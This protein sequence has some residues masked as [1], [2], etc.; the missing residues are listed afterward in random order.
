MSAGLDPGYHP[1][2]RA[3]R[4]G[5][6]SGDQVSRG[7]AERVERS[8]ERWRRP[9]LA[10]GW[11]GRTRRAC[12]VAE[13]MCADVCCCCWCC[14]RSL[15]H[16]NEAAHH[17][18][19]STTSHE[20]APPQ[21]AGLADRD[22]RSRLRESASLGEFD[23]GCIRCEAFW[24][25]AADRYVHPPQVHLSALPPARWCRPRTA[26]GGW[27]GCGTPATATRQVTTALLV[28]TTTRGERRTPE[29]QRAG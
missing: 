4:A 23:H 17:R 15:A 19:Q 8:D 12:E 3:Q 11:K 20:L 16:S 29:Q 6:S 22:K 24:E 21:P 27:T 10:G 18:G 26:S 7:P 13:R 9:Q 5:R 14:L 2:E 1:A 25:F 28:P